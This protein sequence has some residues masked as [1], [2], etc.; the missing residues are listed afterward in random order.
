MEG[1]RA[2]VLHSVA[3]ACGGPCWPRK[4]CAHTCEIRT[5]SLGLMSWSSCLLCGAQVSRNEAACVGG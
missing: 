5:W 3:W 1:C 4:V 2:G